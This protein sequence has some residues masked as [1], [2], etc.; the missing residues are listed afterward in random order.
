MYGTEQRYRRIRLP[1]KV[2][3]VSNEHQDSAPALAPVDTTKIFVKSAPPTI[4]KGI[5]G[6]MSVQ[7]KKELAEKQ[8]VS[9]G[10]K[11]TLPGL[12]PQDTFKARLDEE[13][14]VVLLEMPTKPANTQEISQPRC[15]E[16]RRGHE[17]NTQRNRRSRLWW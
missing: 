7:A 4:L 12:A 15:A 9:N 16:D 8:K 6:S 17:E 2:L 5:L 10:H 14:D 1:R 11:N 13:I 3:K